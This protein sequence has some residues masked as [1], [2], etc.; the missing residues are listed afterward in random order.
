MFWKIARR[1][2]IFIGFN[3]SRHSVGNEHMTIMSTLD[4]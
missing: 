3:I 4:D 2:E 1:L